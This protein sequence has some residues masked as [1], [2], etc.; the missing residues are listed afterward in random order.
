MFPFELA[1][2]VGQSARLGSFL[3]FVRFGSITKAAIRKYPILYILRSICER[4]IPRALEPLPRSFIVILPSP[5]PIFRVRHGTI[6]WWSG[7]VMRLLSPETEI[8]VSSV[9]SLIAERG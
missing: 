6:W 7:P 8:R 9:R 4:R 1:Q 3:R 5:S 2:P